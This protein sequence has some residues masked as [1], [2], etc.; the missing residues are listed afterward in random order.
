[1]Y[2]HFLRGCLNH[3][4]GCWTWFRCL[5]NWAVALLRYHIDAAL[6]C[7]L[8]ILSVAENH[9]FALG[10]CSIS[11]VLVEARHLPK[12]RDLYSHTR[13]THI[14]ITLKW[15]GEKVDGL[16]WSLDLWVCDA[17]LVRCVFEWEVLKL[18]SSSN[19]G[20]WNLQR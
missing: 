7:G 20:T 8:A 13:T 4:C 17:Q 18:L 11:L 6:F 15:R 9:R 16:C 5:A 14:F 2:F 12:V 3:T 19:L 10:L 1:M